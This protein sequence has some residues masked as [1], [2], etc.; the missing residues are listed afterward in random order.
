M[1]GSLSDMGLSSAARRFIP[2][3]TER[4]K[5]AHLR[6]FLSGSR[7]LA[8]AISGGLAALGALIVY[9]LSPRLDPFAV[10]P[11]YLACAVVPISGLGQIQTGIAQS[12]E[13]PNLALVPFYIL[14]QLAMTLAVGGAGGSAAPPAP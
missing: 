6:G 1:I 14:R 11:L 13:W 12:Y 5:A 10:V 4:G 2:E 8:F 7:W 9:L 3:Y